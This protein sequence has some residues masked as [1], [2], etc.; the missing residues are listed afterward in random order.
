MVAT[1]SGSFHLSKRNTQELLRDCFGV[2]ISLGSVSNL[3]R[4]MSKALEPA[5]VE[6]LESISSSRRA[7]IDESGWF[8]R[9][10]QRYLWT[11]C[12]AKATVFVIRETRSQEVARELLDKFS[13]IAGT[14]GYGAYHYLS[15][16]RRQFCWAH[17]IRQFR[18]LTLYEEESKLLG[19]QLL[20]VA[21]RVFALWH[22]RHRKPRRRRAHFVA[23]MAPLQSELNA[24]LRHGATLSSTKASGMCRTLLR[25]ERSLWVFLEHKAVEPTNNAAERA[26]RPAVLW[27]KRSFGTDSAA[28]SRF[29]ERVLTAVASLRARGANVLRFLVTTC[30]AAIAGTRPPSLLEA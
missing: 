21:E 26:L 9:A 22:R 30:V 3:E 4:A 15:G 18:G 1:C 10:R 11:V 24:L 25:H 23:A 17:L 20:S 5:Y 27:R 12:T 16:A 13:G 6:A 19:N 2:C 7:N 29:V 28:G 14:D 8:E